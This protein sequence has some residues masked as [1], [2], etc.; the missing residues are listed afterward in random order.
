MAIRQQNAQVIEQNQNIL[1]SFGIN[2]NNTMLNFNL[3][4]ELPVTNNEDLISLE[5]YINSMDNFKSFV[6][7]CI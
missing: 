4:V 3:P 2:S 1:T 5:S 6:S 7:R